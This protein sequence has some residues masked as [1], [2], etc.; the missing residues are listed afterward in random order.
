ML[1]KKNKSI[2]SVCCFTWTN[3]VPVFENAPF[4][5][6]AHLK[7]Q[8][9][10]LN[11]F[12]ALLIDVGT[13]C[14]KSGL[15]VPRTASFALCTVLPSL[16]SLRFCAFGVWWTT[17]ELR[18]ALP[19]LSITL[20]TAKKGAASQ[21]RSGRAVFILGKKA[22]MSLYYLVKDQGI[23]P[24]GLLDLK[25]LLCLCVTW[26]PEVTQGY[27]AKLFRSSRPDPIMAKACKSFQKQLDLPL[28]QRQSLPQWSP[29]Q[30]LCFGHSQQ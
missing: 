6:N 25:H 5:K 23:C 10:K 2:L 16:L 14:Q 9:Y 11:A 18:Q 1:L 30:G 7:N 26:W 3:S 20:R 8:T 24:T 12:Q 21:A 29:S 27:K 4:E 28:W 19:R 15:G 22:R 17:T 13:L